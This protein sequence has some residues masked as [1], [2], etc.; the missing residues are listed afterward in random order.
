MNRFDMNKQEEEKFI[1]QQKKNLHDS[2]IAGDFVTLSPEIE[3]AYRHAFCCG[4]H[5]G[6]EFGSEKTEESTINSVRAALHLSNWVREKG[7]Q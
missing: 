5:V 3:M 2:G 7:P 1:E 6:Y 4:F